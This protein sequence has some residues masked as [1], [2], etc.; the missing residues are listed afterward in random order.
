[1]QEPR[2]N[3][4]EERIARPDNYVF[5]TVGLL[6]FVSQTTEHTAKRL[7]DPRKRAELR[8]TRNSPARFATRDCRCNCYLGAF[9]LLCRVIGITVSSDDRDGRHSS[10]ERIP[11]KTNTADTVLTLIKITVINEKVKDHLR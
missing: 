9:P 8:N 11:H 10:C 5:L 3:I 2:T 4:I 6:A 1:M 7:T